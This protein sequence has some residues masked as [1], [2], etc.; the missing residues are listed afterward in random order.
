MK[1]RSEVG[2]KETGPTFCWH[3]NRM[4]MRAPGHGRFYFTLFKGNDGIARR[5]HGK[6][7]DREARPPT[8]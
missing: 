7:G 6:C 5:I 2:T 8:P 1:A 4:L 3:C